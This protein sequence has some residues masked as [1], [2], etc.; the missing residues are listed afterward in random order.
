MP[1]F[2]LFWFKNCFIDQE[3]L[4]AEGQE[5]AKKNMRSVVVQN[6]AMFETDY[7]L[8]FYMRFLS[9]LIHTLEK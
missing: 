3:N 2:I 4:R 6:N 1:N 5:F 9:D 8:A 7:F